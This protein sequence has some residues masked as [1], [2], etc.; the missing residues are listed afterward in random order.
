MENDIEKDRYY[1]GTFNLDG[2]Q[3]TGQLVHNI[4]KGIIILEVKILTDSLGKYYGDLPYIVGKL[5]NGA[6]ITL[7]NNTCINNQTQAFQFQT[8]DFRCEYFIISNKEVVNKKYNQ[9]TCSVSNALAWSELSRIHSEP[10]ATSVTF[11]YGDSINK[12]SNWFGC[13]ITFSTSISNGLGRIPIPEHVEIT[14]YL[15]ITIKS[16]EQIEIPKFID[17]RNKILSLISFAIKDNVNIEKQYLFNYD[18]K[19]E[20][21][22]GQY[23]NIEYNLISSDG[24]KT[25]SP[26]SIYFYNF[27][28]TQLPLIMSDDANKRLIDLMPIFDLYLSLFKYSDMPV[29]MVFLNI[30]Q[31]LETFHAR[32]ICDDKKEFEKSINRRF[33]TS[34]KCE[35]IKELL[36]NTTQADKNNNYI[37]LFSRVNDLLIG[38]QYGGLFYDFYA[39]K[40]SFAQT[41]VDTRHYY[42]HYGD[43]KKDKALKKEDIPNAIYILKLLLEFHVCKILGIDLTQ[44]TRNALSLF[45]AKTKTT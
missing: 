7:F 35:E 38:E 27:T 9:Y 26:T 40:K 45:Y 18:D 34:P 13:D 24:Y 12:K 29:E 5:D 6:I 30:I 15:K 10:G 31:A 44:K 39:V 3:Y 14:E 28:L 23:E 11:D 36:W 16:K 1:V 37:L 43:N 32:F 2:K 20:I 22:P 42:T 17:I 4:K 21:I 33:A 19:F 25:V 41:I 8:L